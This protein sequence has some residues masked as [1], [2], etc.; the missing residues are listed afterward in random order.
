MIGEEFLGV[1]CNG[2]GY[3]RLRQDVN[4]F[5]FGDGRRQTADGNRLDFDV[6]NDGIGKKSFRKFSNLL[7][8]VYGAVLN[9]DEVSVGGFCVDVI[10]ESE[11]ESVLGEGFSVNVGLIRSGEYRDFP[12]HRRIV[13]SKSCVIILPD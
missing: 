12:E 1:F 13:L 11:I 6:F 9:F 3:A 10:G 7:L 4:G 2:V 5:R 8:N